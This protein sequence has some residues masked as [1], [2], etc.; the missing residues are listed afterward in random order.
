MARFRYRSVPPAGAAATGEIEAPDSAA[1]VAQLQSAGHY[2]LEV[3]AA[4]LASGNAVSP[5]AA[6]PSRSGRALPIAAAALAMRQLATLIEAGVPLDRALSLAADLMQGSP[7]SDCLQRVRA[8]VMAG[9]AVSSA[10][11]AEADAFGALATAMAR[12]GE[13]S[14]RLGQA[15]GIAALWLERSR[16]LGQSLR[17]ALAYPLVL[18]GVSAFAIVFLLA[19]V[20]PRFA[21]MFGDMADRLPWS[22]RVVLALTDA[23]ADHG[24]FALA[25]LILAALAVRWHMSW[26][27]GAL[28]WHGLLLRVPLVGELVRKREAERFARALSGLVGAGV[29]LSEAAELARATLVNQAIAGATAGL[30]GRIR[31]GI[32]PATALAECRCFPDAMIGLATVG[33]ETGRLAAMLEQ[34]A[35]LHRREVEVRANRLLVLLTPALTIGLG[36]LIAAIILSLLLPMLG[37]Y[38]TIL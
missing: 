1:A 20:M 3:A 13:A 8:R 10:L 38:E 11:A 25:A 6:A 35:E 14:G 16:D 29:A 5:A 12:A 34:A 31:E 30:S 4:V 2:P 36:L 9:E 19:F 18:L 24:P 23:L 7:A 37:L 32:A 17:S 33:E 28:F 15:L 26:A 21:A 22:T 27:A